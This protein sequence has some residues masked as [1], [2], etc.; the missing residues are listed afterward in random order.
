MRDLLS[1]RASRAAGRRAL[2]SAAASLVVSACA[3]GP[4]YHAPVVQVAPAYQ[5][6]DSTRVTA[7]APDSGAGPAAATAPGDSA[8]A[9]PGGA[10]ALAALTRRDSAG[11]TISAAPPPSPFWNELGDS[12]LV[13][14]IQEGLRANPDVRVAEARL[15]DARASRR[16]AAF[17]FAPT[18]TASGGFSHQR[19][20]EAQLPGAPSSLRE[21]SLWDA[22]FDASWEI[23]VFGRV[24]K[25]VGAAKAFE[26]SAEQDVRDVQVSLAAELARTYLELRGAQAQLAVAQRN[27]QNERHTLALTED[28]L[29]AG[30]GT[31]L[32]TARAR[33]QLSTT[34]AAIPLLEA[35]V[36]GNQYR[37]ATLLGR[38]PEE[39]PPEV[40]R[41]AELPPLPETVHVG[42]PSLL[43]ARRPDVV[44]A[45][46]TLAA[47]TMLIGA[48]EAEYLPRFSVGASVGRTATALD[49]LGGNGATRFFLGPRITWSFL[50]F[51][52]VHA[53][54]DESRARAEEAR[55]TYS[56]TVQ[57]A[58]A[59]V[60]TSLVTYDRARARL[61]SLADAASASERAAE[62]ARLRFAEGVSDFLQVLDAERT[63]L[64]AENQLVRGRTDAATALVAVYKAVGGTWPGEGGAG[65]G[66]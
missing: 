66:N 44:S 48:A 1:S 13:R 16:L 51:G 42:S 32:D 19:L 43:V 64:D 46:R 45:E 14:L 5:A 8:M 23:D 12:A 26:S 6:L 56:A 25:S 60:E 41:A 15:R 21:G 38:T 3:V 11:S 59:E 49:S 28:R 31:A 39:L 27:A 33:A 50:D 53:R 36:A 52:R 58:L 10:A 37:I 17:D 62:L 4:S 24:R 18:I 47:Q 9:G 34:E 2:A 55:A 7:P 35:A 22:G 40:T 20:A 54:V 29:A 63:L 65:A 61:A 57:R 30:K